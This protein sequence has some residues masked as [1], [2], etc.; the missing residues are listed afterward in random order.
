MK[1]LH[2]GQG[3]EIDKNKKKQKR[4]LANDFAS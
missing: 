3:K 2:W 4:N 1:F